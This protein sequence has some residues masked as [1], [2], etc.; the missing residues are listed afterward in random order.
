MKLRPWTEKIDPSTI[1][2]TVIVSENARRNTR[3]R[4]S[5]TGGVE[6]IKHNPTVSYCRCKRCNASRAKGQRVS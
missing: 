3:K 5:Y 1:P 2:D 6:W 4:K